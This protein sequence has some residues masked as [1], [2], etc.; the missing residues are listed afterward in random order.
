MKQ[1]PVKS[2]Q[3]AKLPCKDCG[4]HLG[5]RCPKCDEDFDHVWGKER[6]KDQTE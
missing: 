2:G 6:F 5:I 3:T 4:T 1:V